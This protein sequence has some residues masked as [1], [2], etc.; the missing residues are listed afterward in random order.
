MD[1]KNTL[2]RA[3]VGRRF[4][5]YLTLMN[6]GQLKR[7]RQYIAENY[8][9]GAL[10]EQSVGERVQWHKTFFAETGKLRVYQVLACDE[11]HLLALV[12][13]QLNKTVYLNEF[14]VSPDYP[15]KILA[16]RKSVV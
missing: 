16:D 7:L 10:G 6:S 1:D 9:P 12:Y 4:I 2:L 8:M 5:A 15:H 14:K 11:H 3:A 13:A